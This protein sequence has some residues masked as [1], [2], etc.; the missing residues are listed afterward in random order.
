MFWSSWMVAGDLEM[1]PFLVEGTA[2][3][4][5]FPLYLRCFPKGRDLQNPICPMDFRCWLAGITRQ[6]QKIAGASISK[7]PISKQPVYRPIDQVAVS[8]LPYKKLKQQEAITNCG[9]LTHTTGVEAPWTSYSR[10]RLT[11]I[12][13]LM[14]SL[15]LLIQ[16]HKFFSC[17]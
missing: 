1:S 5:I 2:T 12:R 3:K 9:S 15:L 6:I 14:P 13:G 4:L 11:A 7:L 8:F 16:P 17:Q 10:Y